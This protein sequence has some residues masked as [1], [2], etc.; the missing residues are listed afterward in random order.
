M[1]QDAVR[2]AFIHNHEQVLRL[3]EDGANG[4]H[5][6]RTF[7]VDVYERGAHPSLRHAQPQSDCRGIASGWDWGG[8]PSLRNKTFVRIV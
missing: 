5:Q 8:A 4:V 3:A 2:Q 7:D 1:A 6:R